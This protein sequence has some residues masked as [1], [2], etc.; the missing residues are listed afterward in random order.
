MPRALQTIGACFAIDHS[1]DTPAIVNFLETDT[2]RLIQQATARYRAAGYVVGLDS[3][4]GMVTYSS[5]HGEKTYTL[6]D[7][8]ICIP[9]E[10]SVFVAEASG[11]YISGIAAT[12]QYKTEAI[13]LLRLIGED[14]AFRMQLLFGKEGRDYVLEDGYFSLVKQEDG[15]D[16]SMTIVSPLAFFAGMTAKESPNLRTPGVDPNMMVTYEGKTTLQTYVEMMD[17]CDISYYPIVFDY[18]EFEQEVAAVDDVFRKYY[19]IYTNPKYMTEELYGKMLAE[20]QEAGAGEIQADLQRQLEEYLA[21]D[22]S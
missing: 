19:L 17:T 14:E 21:K 3:V 12:S 16:Y 5:V 22:P 15:S 7:G 9:V 11:N 10:E 6:E 18:S 13:S 4:L 2:V 20:L 1:G 8:T